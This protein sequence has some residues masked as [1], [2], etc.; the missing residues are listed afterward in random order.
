MMS[1]GRG[2]ST[3]SNPLP[4]GAVFGVVE[5]DAHGQQLLADLVRASEVAA[6]AGRLTLGNQALDLRVRRLREVDDV[7]N[8]VGVPQHRHRGSSLLWS[9]LSR[10]ES[11]VEGLDE[12][13]E[14][15][16]GGREVEVVAQRV[17]PALTHIGWRLRIISNRPQPDSEF[18]K[19]P[20]RA[21]SSAQQVRRKGQ[22]AAIVGTGE[23]RVTN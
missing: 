23:E 21:F 7:E 4:A 22:R 8:A 14:V 12:I 20:D 11:G 3:L 15:T 18:V 1:G 10:I 9:G 16:D 13:E 2:T 19:A 5:L 17:V 6:V